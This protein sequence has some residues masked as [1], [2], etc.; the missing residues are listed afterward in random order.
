MAEQMRAENQWQAFTIILVLLN[1]K[2]FTP[3]MSKFC[4]R[5]DFK[6]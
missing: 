6:P 1:W 2:V 5:N 3:N 4:L